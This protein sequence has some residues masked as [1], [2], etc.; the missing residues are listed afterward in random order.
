MRFALL[1]DHADGRAIARAL[2]ASGRHHLHAYYGSRTEADARLEWP[3]V[4][5]LTDLEEL[6]ADPAVEAVIVAGKPAERL[7]QL[8]RVLQSERSAF[9]VHPVDAKPDGAYEINMLQGDTHQVVVPLLPLAVNRKVDEIA[10]RL[11]TTG[12][13]SLVELEYRAPDEPLFEGDG[14]AARPTFPG[15]E[16]LRRLG[17]AVAE[18]QAF[19]RDEAV[20]HGE[21]ATIQGRFESGG[22]FRA[23]Y[24][25]RRRTTEI[26]LNV[27][28]PDG[29][30]GSF[31]IGMGEEDWLRLVERFETATTRLRSTPRAAPGSGPAGDAGG[32]PTW[33]DEIR[34]AELDD[35]ARRGI[36]RRKAV[37]L[38]YQAVNED[39][40][41]KGTMTLV[42]CGLLWFIPVLLVISVWLP[43]I[44]W[45]IVPVLF[46]FLLLQL[47]RW[48][49]PAPS[50]S[51]DNIAPGD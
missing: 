51:G 15:W 4:R 10:Q 46:G 20:R 36:E 21:P 27:M 5:F 2:I 18:V 34:A 49:V 50:R 28:G 24:Y 14:S 17:G 41:F 8:R 29:E 45:L 39:V 37:T 32:P 44:G 42:G 33:L 48:F 31:P 26:R 40:G 25:P 38:E 47:L 43:Q 11:E 12:P 30:S 6:L 13:P 9:C 16:V 35:A 22:L 19:A 7:D 23:A 1:G 3:Q